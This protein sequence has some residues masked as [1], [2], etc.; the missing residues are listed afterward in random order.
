MRILITVLTIALLIGC[1]TPT[2]EEP[3]PEPSTPAPEST[4]DRVD[5]V[6]PA[7]VIEVPM[8]PEREPEP[9][10]EPERKPEPVPEPESAPEPL[11]EPEP[12]PA[13]RPAAEAAPE[14]A[15]AEI[16]SPTG[17]LTGNI[18]ILQNGREQPFGSLHLNQT[19]IAWQPA[20]E[21]SAAA[22]PQQQIV[23]RRSRFFPQTMVVTRGTEVRFPNMDSIQHNVFSLT[24]GHQ[25]DVGLYGEG[26]GR[27]HVFNGTGMVEMYCNVHPNMAAFMLVLDTPHFIAPDENGDFMLRDLP[28]GPGELL[29]WNYRAEEVLQRV[30]IR[31]TTSN[32]PLALSVNIT[33][34]AVPQHTNKHGETYGRDRARP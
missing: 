32:D 8:E 28:V 11:P 4:A 20:S 18:S 16:T 19:V 29:I 26:E 13:T 10:P 3:V 14:A 24:P 12:E 5:P 30:P 22:M 7:P 31:L 9:E 15:P 2:L 17:T 27:S 33:R 21:A 25:F 34:P 1:A 6:Q 23:T